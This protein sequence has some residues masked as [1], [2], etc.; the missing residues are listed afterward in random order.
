MIYDIQTLKDNK[1]KI[2]DGDII[3]V[4][5]KPGIFSLSATII[6]LGTDG[7]WNHAGLAYHGKNDELYIIEADTRKGNVIEPIDKYND[8]KHKFII[9]RPTKMADNRTSYTKKMGLRTIEEAKKLLGLKYDFTAILGFGIEVF[10]KGILKLLFKRLFNPL[11]LRNRYFCSEYVITS[12][13]NAGIYICNGFKPG[14]VSPNDIFRDIV[15]SL[16]LVQLENQYS[17]TVALYKKSPDNR[18]ELLNEIW[19]NIKTQ[20]T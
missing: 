13:R 2:W 1:N 17:D 11:Q 10:G 9:L 8:K 19:N 7:P 3:L 5:R 14:S 18:K 16:T 20:E 4:H 12:I 6:Q 15:G